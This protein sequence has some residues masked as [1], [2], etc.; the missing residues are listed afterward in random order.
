MKI[1]IAGKVAPSALAV[2]QEQSDCRPVQVHVVE[3]DRVARLEDRPQDRRVAGELARD[4]IAD[5]PVE[6]R[7]LGARGASSWR[8]PATMS[9]PG[10]VSPQCESVTHTFT[11]RTPVAEERAVLMPVGGGVERHPAQRPLLRREH[12]ALTEIPGERIR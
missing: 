11:A 12:R 1:V 9:R 6:P 8:R 4:G 2:F 10:A 7:A 5:R 3:Q